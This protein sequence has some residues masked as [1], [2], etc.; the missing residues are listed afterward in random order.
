M[1]LFLDTGSLDEIRTA[2]GWGVLKGITTNPTL[3]S[4]EEGDFLPLVKEICSIVDGDVS[5]ETASDDTDVIVRQGHEIVQIAENAVVKVALTPNGI[6]A[7]RKLSD[8]GIKVNVTLCFTPA[9]ALL[10]AEAGAYIVSPFL[11]R[12]DDVATDSLRTLSDICEIYAVQGYE[13]QVL[14]ASLRHPMH[15][16][17]A[18]RMGADIATMPFKV[19]EQL[20]KHPLTD[21]GFERFID[22]WEAAKPRLGEL[23]PSMQE[24]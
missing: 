16:V 18:A 10:A 21:A 6:A 23:L 4:K 8:E 22:D 11:G 19:F 2:N 1:K 5:I 14:A 24:A 13:T 17:E 12:L 7:T 20:F 15:V 3:I 9:Q